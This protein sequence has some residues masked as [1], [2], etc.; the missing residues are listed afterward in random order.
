M[1]LFSQC[2]VSVSSCSSG[3]EGL[4]EFGAIPVSVGLRGSSGERRAGLRWAVCGGR[5]RGGGA[6]PGLRAPG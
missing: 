6:Q 2:S 3:G 4:C 1:T 5:V